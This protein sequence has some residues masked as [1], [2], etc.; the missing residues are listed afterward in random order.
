MHKTNIQ[1]ITQITD[2]LLHLNIP[3][4]SDWCLINRTKE[5]YDRIENLPDVECKRLSDIF[6]TVVCNTFEK[7][8]EYPDGICSLVILD[9]IH[10]K[11]DVQYDTT[12]KSGCVYVEVLN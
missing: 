3:K 4:N 2:A 7:P 6:A 12:K 8:T 9:T 5:E 10:L 11:L 1:Y